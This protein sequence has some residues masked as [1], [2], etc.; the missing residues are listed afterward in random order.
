MHRERGNS[1]MTFLSLIVVPLLFLSLGVSPG[2]SVCA[3]GWVSDGDI[4]CYYFVRG[5][6]GGALTW[7]AAQSFCRSLRTGAFLAEIVSSTQ[8]NFLT[9]RLRQQSGANYWG[10]KIFFAFSNCFNCS[11]FIIDNWWIGINDI[12]SEGNYVLANSNLAVSNYTGWAAG[13]PNGGSA[14]NCVHLMAAA[15][16]G[17]NDNDCF[18]RGRWPLCQYFDA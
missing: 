12:A 13:E 11:T 7:S 1:I 6:G 16:Y 15:G 18:Q 3:S 2:D 8:Q 14:E 17:W 5:T 10:K 4:S 9:T